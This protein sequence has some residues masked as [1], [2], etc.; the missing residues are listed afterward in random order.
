MKY[1]DRVAQVGCSLFLFLIIQYNIS[2][3][4]TS[5]EISNLK[6][7]KEKKKSLSS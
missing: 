7:E 3:W 6:K 2:L 4:T 1:N 5:T